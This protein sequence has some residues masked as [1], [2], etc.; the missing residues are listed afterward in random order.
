MKMNRILLSGTLCAAA[1]VGVACSHLMEKED[2]PIA[3]EK[4]PPAVQ[5]AIAKTLAGQ[6]PDKI[7]M[8]DEDGK[9]I[10]EVTFHVNGQERSA[11]ITPAGDVLELESDLAVTS[12]PAPV[13]S[14]IL[15]KY[16]GAKIGEA[17]DVSAN[18]AQF[19][20]AGIKLADGSEHELQVSADGA[21][22]S[23]KAEDEKDE[24]KK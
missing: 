22:R 17:S 12:L 3:L 14:A 5:A 11:D 2:A 6:K 10:Y 15:K 9:Q 1:C 23:D 4:T 21:I 24:D 20:E 13:T 19:Y 18:G 8:E 7:V 16:P